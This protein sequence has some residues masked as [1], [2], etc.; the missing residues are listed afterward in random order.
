MS[1]LE[2]IPSEPEESEAIYTIETVSRLTRIPEEDIVIYHR[3][4]VISSTRGGD[5]SQLLF[6]ETAVHQ[7][8]RVAFLLAEYEMNRA[9]LKLVSGLFQEIESLRAELRFLREKN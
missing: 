9:A 6:D 1:P 5:G 4:G 2:N 3:T 7:L 8:R